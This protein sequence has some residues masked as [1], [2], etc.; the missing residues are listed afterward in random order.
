MAKRGTKPK[1]KTFSIRLPEDDYR[2]LKAIAEDRR[3][4]LT[5]QYVV[6]YAVLRLL[7]NA[8]SGQLDLTNPL[9]TN[10]PK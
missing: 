8:E 10:R 1:Q 9:K 2:K 6:E 4:Q 5:V 7:A 3:P